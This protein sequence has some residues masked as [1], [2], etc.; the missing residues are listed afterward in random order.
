[1]QIILSTIYL[2]INKSNSMADNLVKVKFKSGKIKEVSA[3]I[4]YDKN[5]QA[6]HGF[7]LL[8][9]STEFSEPIDPQKKIEKKNEP[10]MVAAETNNGENANEELGAGVETVSITED[11]IETVEEKVTRLHKD[12]KSEDEIK[13]ETGINKLTIRAIIKKIKK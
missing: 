4:A 10:K 9:G 13:E 1:M 7:A 5:Y 11:K 6:S 8:D 3:R 12:K 2:C